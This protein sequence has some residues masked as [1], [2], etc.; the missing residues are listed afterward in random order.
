MDPIPML[1]ALGFE[2]GVFCEEDLECIR[3]PATIRVF[4]Y[5]LR[6][7]SVAAEKPVFVQT[8]RTKMATTQ[9]MQTSLN[10]IASVLGWKSGKPPPPPRGFANLAHQ[11]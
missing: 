6:C 7:Q 2:D 5:Q 4:P 9:S 3:N 8:D 10:K 1:I 11:V